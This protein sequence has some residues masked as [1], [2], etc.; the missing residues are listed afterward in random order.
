M[1]KMGHFFRTV[2]TISVAH[3]TCGRQHELLTT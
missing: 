2:L 1:D 3:F